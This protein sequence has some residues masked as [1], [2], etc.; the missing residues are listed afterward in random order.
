MGSSHVFERGRSSPPSYSLSPLAD[1][2]GSEFVHETMETDE[3]GIPVGQDSNIVEGSD[4]RARH[5][6]SVMTADIYS[7]RFNGEGGDDNEDDGERRTPIFD[8]NLVAT[9]WPSSPRQP[10][11]E[12]HDESELSENVDDSDYDAAF[13]FNLPAPQLAASVHDDHSSLSDDEDMDAGDMSAFGDH[14]SAS[15]PY[16]ASSKERHRSESE[17]T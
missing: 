4:V 9:E 2:D 14:F 12:S 11:A 17:I 7:T 15:F 13:G 6:L 10:I 5:N 16:G 3:G 8:E 1:V